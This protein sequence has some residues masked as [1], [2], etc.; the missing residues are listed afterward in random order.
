MFRDQKE[1][2]IKHGQS[3][4]VKKIRALE[5][6]HWLELSREEARRY[7]LECSHDKETLQYNNKI[8][9]SEM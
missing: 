6:L 4:A 9:A 7:R 1:E 2:E 5:K 3:D 8:I